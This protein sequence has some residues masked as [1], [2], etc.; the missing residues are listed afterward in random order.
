MTANA[1]AQVLQLFNV[2]GA[3][4]EQTWFDA[5]DRLHGPRFSVSVA[6]EQRGP[7][8]DA[9]DFEVSG[10][11]RISVEPADDVS[12]Q[13][14]R[15]A[16]RRIDGPLPDLVHGHFGPRVLHLAPY[17]QRNVPG[18]ISLYGYDASRLLRDPCWVERYRWAAQRGAVFVVLSRDMQRR[19][20]ELGLPEKKVRIIHLGIDPDAWR[21]DPQPAPLTP[22]FLFVGRLSPKK[23]IDTLLEAVSRFP[24]ATLGL[25]GNGPLRNELQEQ[26]RGLGLADRVT[27]YGEQQ[28]AAFTQHARGCTALVVPSVVAPDGDEEGTPVV[29]MEAQALGLPVVTT[30]H[31]GN[32]EVLPPG[33]VAAVVPERDAAAL[34]AAMCEAA[35]MTPSQRRARQDAGRSHI[36]EHFTL[37]KMVKE[38]GYLYT[39]LIAERRGGE[40]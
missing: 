30:R 23:G 38:L 10:C 18:V 31:A 28:R 7:L 25:V 5:V 19:M 9:V 8:A 37:G 11:E 13:M 26:T 3:P 40:R 24:G 32:P 16:E 34:A 21:F 35:E 6:C 14:Q 17:L 15:L 4:T 12:A 36:E 22:R 27:F 20:I 2:F 29:L 39:S 1:S 33:S